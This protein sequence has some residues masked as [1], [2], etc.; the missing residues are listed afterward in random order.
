MVAK[1]P[2]T[3]TQQIAV[4]LGALSSG[5]PVLDMMRQLLATGAGVELHGVFIEDEEL[6]Q[7][8][9]LPLVNELCRLTLSV[10][11]I[12]GARFDRVIA[13]RRRTARK[14]FEG[15]A[16]RRGVSHTFRTAHGSIVSLLQ[17]TIHTSNVTIF[18]PIRQLSSSAIGQPMRSRLTARRIVV[19][20][21]DFDT[22]K[23]ALHTVALLTK[24]RPDRFSILLRAQNMAE[25]HAMEQLVRES[26]PNRPFRLLLLPDREIDSLIASVQSERG[27]ML[28]IG[29]TETSLKPELLGSLLN[30]LECP[31]CL[32]RPVEGSPSRDP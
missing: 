28:V 27:D 20:V 14:M 15:L 3:A 13:L 23:E 6:Q 4:V 32:V 2:E 12:N 22:G 11:E 19:V 8:A 24:G 7:A 5:Q 16:Q 21:D 17:E 18:E 29:A 26:L 25:L 30:R 9:A 31:V 1:K 10:R